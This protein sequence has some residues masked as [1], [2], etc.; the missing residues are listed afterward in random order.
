MAQ[1]Q[2]NP[3][4]GS[5]NSIFDLKEEKK[6][7]R[8]QFP[9]SMKKF[10]AIDIGD[11]IV[12]D[13]YPTFP[14]DHIKQSCRYI[15][16]TLPL[17]VPPMT[18]FFVRTHWYFIKK[19]AL[20]EGW[21]T[22]ITKGRSG[23][24]NINVPTVSEHAFSSS[25]GEGL[26]NP[27][28]DGP[29][30]LACHFGLPPRSYPKATSNVG[31]QE[32]IVAAADSDTQHLA[33]TPGYMWPAYINILPFVAYQKIWRY[34][35]AP[36]NLLQDNKIYFPDN[37]SCHWWLN[38]SASNLRGL[39]F[40]PEDATLPSSGSEKDFIV[41][42]VNS[43]PTVLDGSNCVNLGMLRYANYQDDY[44]T[45][46][47]P[48]LVRGEETKLEISVSSDLNKLFAEFLD[49]PEGDTSNNG[50][51]AGS[52]SSPDLFIQ[53]QNGYNRSTGSS[54]VSWSGGTPVSSIP[55][56]WSKRLGIDLANASFTSAFT[57]NTLRNLLA[58]S[59]YQERAAT[60]NGSYNEQ[61]R[62]HF[63]RRPNSP[64]YEPI[65]LGGSTDVVNFAPVIQTSASTQNQPIGTKGAL[66][67]VAGGAK[68]FE[69]DCHDFGYIIGLMF[70]APETIYQG[71]IDRE[72]TNKTFDEEFMPE[73]ANLGFEPVFNQELFA[74]AN[75]SD[76]LG[77]WGWQT[78]YA[79]LKHR[80]NMACGM[81]A[82]PTTV[83]RQFGAQVIR[84]IP[85]STDKLSA[86]W[87]SFYHNVS[88]DWLSYYNY[89]AFK[90]Q[91]ASDVD[92]VRALP[93]Q[94]TPE[95][96]GF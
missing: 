80:R 46:A 48:W 87:L 11:L 65:Y 62:V 79:Y 77:L 25:F 43:A 56:T 88:R 31:F 90:L 95:T 89:P 27:R 16:D 41:P 8:S 17:E 37:L 34:N 12:C 73:K 70:V 4:A 45:S 91:F 67:S 18:S 23:S 7:A 36:A 24:I 6:V 38:Y 42:R 82:L 14:G 22:H 76:N 55:S 53:N 84:R 29:T 9:F 63:G 10:D 35:Y 59:V 32:P 47:K 40:V 96:F 39:A 1:T 81:F 72:W 3:F 49:R 83:D 5:K 93:W 58:M 69:F 20:W 33:N 21:E 51:Y 74:R 85:Q 15:L 44:F 54:T 78:K 66:G 52:G 94:S 64:E 26:T 61:I 86:Q 92:L 2:L 30:S 57:A 60:T 68:L 13:W 19:S 50:I 75:A 28:L 71:N